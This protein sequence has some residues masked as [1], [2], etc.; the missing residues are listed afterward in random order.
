MMTLILNLKNSDKKSSSIQISKYFTGEEKTTKWIKTKWSQRVKT[1]P[2]NILSKL[3]RRR[4]IC[5]TD[6]N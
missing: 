6:K 2:Q 1:I 3:V 4:V 5:K